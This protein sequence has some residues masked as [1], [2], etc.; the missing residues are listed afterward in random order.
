MRRRN[1]IQRRSF[2][3]ESLEAR[4][5]LAGDLVAHW[6]ADSLVDSLSDGATVAEWSDGVGQRA[7]AV[8]QGEPILQYASVDGRASVRFDAADGGDLLE[9]S[10]VVNPIAGATDYSLV[11]VFST[12]DTDIRD[13]GDKW[14]NK[15]GIVDGNQNGFSADYGTAISSSG[16]IVAGTSVTFGVPGANVTSTDTGLNDGERHVLFFSRSGNDVALYVDD[17]APVTANNAGGS[18]HASSVVLAIG[19]LARKDGPFTGNISEV[20]VYDGMLTDAE[21]AAVSEEI[22]AYYNNAA[23]QANDDSYSV[24]EDSA[25]LI[26]AVGNGLL[27]NDS[28]ADGDA[29][30][31]RVMSEPEHGALSVQP[32]GSFLYIPEANYFGT[33]TF[34]YSAV[35]SR[36][37]AA[38]TVTINVTS[39]NDNPTATSD[40]YF[41]ALDE[42]ITATLA[43]GLLVNDADIDSPNLTAVLATGPTNGQ[44][45]LDENGTFT[46]TP[47]AGFEG[48][49]TFTYRASDGSASSDAVE[50]TLF[51]GGSPLRINEIL[52]VNIG[53]VETR[54]RA[55]PDDRFRG[56]DLQP[57]WIEIQNLSSATIDIGGFHLTD[58][59]DDLMKW[60]FPDG[61]SIPANESLVVF[62]SRLNV[63]DPALDE[64]GLMHTNFALTIGGE[65]LALTDADGAVLDD[66]GSGYPRQYPGISYGYTPDG[67]LGRLTEATRGAPNTSVAYSG[68]VSDTSFSVDR[69]FYT[70]AFDVA[71]STKSAEAE[72]RYTLDGSEPTADTGTVYSGPITIDNTTILRAAAFQDGM[73]PSNVDTQSYIFMASVLQQSS[74]PTVG[75]TGNVVEFPERWGA[76]QSDYELDPE[77]LNDPA[78]SDQIDDALMALPTLSLTMGHEELFGRRGLYSTPQST[79]EESAS[80]E[81]IYP[82]GRTGFQINAGARMQGGAS[83]NPEHLKHSMSLRFRED[84]GSPELDFPLY[85]DSP[86][87]QFDSIHLRARYNN[88]WI[89]WDQGQRTRGMQMREAWMR[90]TMLAAGESAAGHGKFVHMYLNGL[91][92]GIYEMH[93]R[94][95]ASHYAAYNGGRAQD[96]AASN[97]NVIVDGTNPNELRELIDIVDSKD[98]E[99]I[100]QRLD[101]DNHIVYNIVLEYGG[102]QDL[103]T[104]GNWRAAGGGTAQAPWQFYIWDAERVLEN[105]RQR[106]TQ[107]VSDLMG[108]IRDLDDIDE[109]VVKFGDHIHRLLFNDGAL[110]PEQ[111]TA[112][113]NERIAELE[114]AII[115]ESARWGDARTDRGQ[116]GP[117]TKNDHW[118]PEHNR[119]VND[120]FPVRTENVIDNFRRRNLYPDLNAAEFL[121]G[122][123]R[124]HG[125]VLDGQTLT[126]MNPDGVGTI[127]YTLDGTDPRLP[128]GAVS[129]TATAYANGAVALTQSTRVQM[130]VL[131]GEDWSALTDATFLVEQVADATNIQI[132]EINYHPHNSQTAF[133]EPDVGDN[134]FEFVEVM[135]ISNNP[136]NLAGAR[137]EQAVIDGESEGITYTFGNQVLAPQQRIVI[138]RN[139]EAVRARYGNDIPLASGSDGFDG[140]EGQWTGGRL[141]DGGETLT[142]VDSNGD[143]IQ[144]VAYD[145]GGRWADRADG[146]GSTLE[147]LGGDLSPDD[148]RSWQ[149]SVEVGGTP[150]SGPSTFDPSVVINEVLSNSDVGADQIELFNVSGRTVDLSGYFLTDSSNELNQYA[151]VDGTS[152]TSGGYLVLSETQFGF[153]L[154]GDDSDDIWLLEPD[155]NGRPAKFVD[156]VEFGATQ[157]NTTLGRWPNGTGEL[158]PMTANSLGEGNSGPVAPNLVI[159][160][161]HYNPAAADAPTSDNLEFVELYNPGGAPLDV[162]GWRL[163]KAVDYTF[164]I[165]AEIPA[166]GSVVAVSFDPAA[167]AQLAASFRANYGIAANVPLVGPFSGVLDNG[168]ERLEVDRPVT[169]ADGSTGYI[170]VDRVRYNDDAPWPT[171]PDGTGSSLTRNDAAAY[172]NDAASWLGAIAS[173]GQ[174]SFEPPA[175]DLNNDGLVDN[176]DISILCQSLNGAGED[177]DLDGNGTFDVNDF[178]FLVRGYLRTDAGDA[179]LDGIFNSTD[180]VAVFT[181]AEYEDGIDGNSTWAEGDWNCDGDFGTSDLVAAFQTATYVAAATRNVSSSDFAATYEDP[182]PQTGSNEAQPA[183]PAQIAMEGS[184]Q[185]EL[186]QTV[187]VDQLFAA[188]RDFDLDRDADEWFEEDLI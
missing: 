54:V 29:L 2:H 77:V 185:R 59:Q 56:D 51:V 17:S 21:V 180:L 76:Q 130:R 125:G 65:Y 177:Y 184:R 124:Q 69:G 18:A 146:V 187:S 182:A 47:N 116:R 46:Y 52:A 157:A 139:V 42:P 165:D 88:S 83:R 186:D 135:N 13:D 123:N 99:Q 86:V 5:L 33:D 142:L 111:S 68:V 143:L 136:V 90:D 137:F 103:K 150:G 161:V 39:V 63:T 127:Y 119:I 160:E 108:F 133:G 4:V 75:S 134:Q 92:W 11:V 7:A 19:G 6:Q 152:I 26:V 64:A 166:G 153:G 117:L 98:W 87:S 55:E 105:P 109:Y 84:Y 94:Q 9:V 162:A 172:G 34:T 1:S 25:G 178:Y 179:N 149:A 129:P 27:A 145:D 44:L 126:F 60:Q 14:F 159:S 41:G 91:Y 72:I 10:P 138:A 120:Y 3:A 74:T 174:V 16:Q 20:R 45:N 79:T 128:G 96:Y 15:T 151:V 23:P 82:D 49:D 158:F 43:N 30:T 71:I 73:I 118:L 188:N 168:G 107:P 78:Y 67:E 58:D 113:W 171:T 183:T 97:A 121:V 70:E 48:I 115:A 24:E 32:N 132:S 93:E 101:V 57:D 89:H 102:N 122:G 163:N 106:G 36:P 173:P 66:F 181:A 131:N 170:L 154:K 85:E 114:T 53:D 100:Q 148:G 144:Q 141:G 81:L 110:T 176:S 61:T 104:D 35:D 8:V 22:D 28:D 12:A 164:P 140:P 31:A 175:V 156:A 40:A 169:G 37:S 80:A 147:F 112:R 95:D 38:A 167:D 155:A 62:A 50:V